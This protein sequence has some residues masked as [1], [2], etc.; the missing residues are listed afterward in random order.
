[1][2]TVF[3]DQ[4][5][6][7]TVSTAHSTGIFDLID[8]DGSDSIAKAEFL[9]A[10][11]SKDEKITNFLLESP[12]LYRLVQSKETESAFAMLDRDGGGH[13]C[14]EEFWEFCHSHIINP[15]KAK[16]SPRDQTSKDTEGT[17][18][19]GSDKP[20]TKK[21]RTDPSKRRNKGPRALILSE[22]K[23]T[24]TT[25]VVTFG[26]G[27]L[28]LL[29]DIFVDPATADRLLFLSE[30]HDSHSSDH[31]IPGDILLK[32]GSHSVEGYEILDLMNALDENDRPLKLV[33]QTRS[34]QTEAAANK[35]VMQRQEEIRKKKESEKKKLT[36]MLEKTEKSKQKHKKQMKKA[37]KRIQVLFE[38]CDKYGHGN[39]DADDI[40]RMVKKVKVYKP[41]D[42][43]PF[44][45]E[46]SKVIRMMGDMDNTKT[47][48]E[49][50]FTEFMVRHLDMSKK[51]HEAIASE[52]AF[53]RRLDNFLQAIVSWLLEEPIP[54]SKA[55]LKQKEAK[56]VR[57]LEKKRKEEEKKKKMEAKRK[58]EEAEK[59]KKK[60]KEEIKKAKEKKKKEERFA[61]LPEKKK[62]K[63]TKQLLRTHES[64]K[65]EKTSKYHL[66]ANEYRITFK[67]PMLGLVLDETVINE[68]EERVLDQF[69]IHNLSSHHHIVH[70]IA[71]SHERAK[72]N[73]GAFA[74]GDYIVRVD[75][76]DVDGKGYFDVMGLIRSKP[77]PLDIVFRHLDHPEN[78]M[79][80]KEPTEMET[81]AAVII[82]AYVRRF[83]ARNTLQ[84][85]RENAEVVEV[86]AV[87]DEDWVTDMQDELA[88]AGFTDGQEYLWA[89]VLKELEE[90]DEL[91][92]MTDDWTDW[93]S[94]DDGQEQNETFAEEKEEPKTSLA[95]NTDNI[96]G[97]TEDDGK[98][99]LSAVWQ[100]YQEKEYLADAAR[101]EDYVYTPPNKTRY[102]KPGHRGTHDTDA[103]TATSASTVLPT[104]N[105][106]Y[107]KNRLRYTSD[108]VQ[109]GYV[110]TAIWTPY[111]PVADD[112]LVATSGSKAGA[113][114]EWQG[115]GYFDPP[116]AVQGKIMSAPKRLNSSYHQPWIVDQRGKKDSNKD[117]K[118]ISVHTNDL[119]NDE[120]TT[121][122][123][124]TKHLRGKATRLPY[125]RRKRKRRLIFRAGNA[126]HGL[127]RRDK[128]AQSPAVATRPT[129]V[130]KKT[131]K[132]KKKAGRRL[133]QRRTT[134]PL[135]TQ[136][137]ASDTD[138]LGALLKPL[139][140]EPLE[141]PKIRKKDVG[142]TKQQPNVQRQ[143]KRKEAVKALR[144][145]KQRRSGMKSVAI[146]ETTAL[147]GSHHSTVLGEWYYSPRVQARLEMQKK[148]LIEILDDELNGSLRDERSD[149]GNT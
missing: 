71:V 139:K 8:A 2:D 31:L 144:K 100:A 102:G 13:I 111:L 17:Q 62:F 116:S 39:L 69:E 59:A 142:Q 57:K 97:G 141:A 98:I 124:P 65:K 10:I 129:D 18:R 26:D 43:L 50:E 115:N 137:D 112:K 77:R 52:S 72:A 92:Y 1:M 15:E 22:R 126:R 86:P 47:I 48:D 121:D 90:I 106:Y 38:K 74:I 42:D 45:E 132:K 19:K 24:D 5:T 128:A 94:S 11:Q 76:V 95:S 101:Y 32:V 122:G 117:A 135:R 27:D 143:G 133:I 66:N 125:E 67:T 51:E 46:I 104:M 118:T 87:T 35:L 73:P 89:D 110:P 33:F 120:T 88:L 16:K 61:K 14:F 23:V 40:R 20:V 119:I 37:K 114:M 93:D 7:A 28:K 21:T 79:K 75:D 81:Q 91:R 78:K 138:D 4:P 49:E 85:R 149:K 6:N 123:L 84:A 25:Y 82:Q 96:E 3:L 109:S 53:M 134:Y 68:K 56:K 136:Q 113:V 108:S 58:K 34:E 107:A 70:I 130:G 41:D 30:V 83:L 145:E 29:F 147:H 12:W 63:K 54:L 146:P 127:M 55:Q 140:F 105:D 9:E 148:L 44:D 80:P 64:K 131:R 99:K 60:R 103:T 36:D